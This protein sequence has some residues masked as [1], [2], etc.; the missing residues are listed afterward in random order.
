MGCASPLYCTTEMVKTVWERDETS[1]WLVAA[2]WRSAYPAR[3]T[4]ITSSRLLTCTAQ[5]GTAHHDKV[6]TFKQRL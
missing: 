1:F 5:H 6:R 3:S 2:V 4:L